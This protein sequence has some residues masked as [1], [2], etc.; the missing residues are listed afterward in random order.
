MKT[1]KPDLTGERRDEL[2]ALSISL[3]DDEKRLFISLASG[4]S[5]EEIPF[6]DSAQNDFN[7]WEQRKT[8]SFDRELEILEVIAKAREELKQ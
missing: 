8:L 2:V 4:E 5:I 1:L 6:Y 7:Y 3:T